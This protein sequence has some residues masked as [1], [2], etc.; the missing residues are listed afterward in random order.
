MVKHM[1]YMHLK[2]TEILKINFPTLKIMLHNSKERN[3][4]I[5]LF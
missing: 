3:N 1:V 4:Y 2:K 5:K